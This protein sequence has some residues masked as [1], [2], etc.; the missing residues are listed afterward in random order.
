MGL[1]IEEEDAIAMWVPI[2]IVA[3]FLQTARTAAQQRLRSLLSVS[4]AGFVRYLYGVPLAVIAV[5]AVWRVEGTLPSPPGRF[6]PIVAGAGLAQI[7]GTI[8]MIHAFD[9][10]DY[11]IGT[12]YTKTEIVQVAM[13]SLVILGEPL[14]PL[15]WVASLLCFAGVVVLAGGRNVWRVRDR[16]ALFGLA[17]G[18]LFAITS[19][20]IRAAA[21]SL[22]DASVA[23]RAL[24]TLAV[25]NSMQ[26]VM[27]GGY[28][29]GREREQLGLAVRHW[30]SSAV[31]GVLS[32]CGSAC[33]AT[34]FT[35]ENAARVR[36]FGQV[37]IV[38][39]FGVARV[40]LGEHHGR[41]EYAASAL[42]IAGVVGVLAA[43]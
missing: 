2:T 26:V 37:E 27:H 40:W 34:A 41:R 36:T 7:V 29:A 17:A 18:G 24:L 38:I 20:G 6:W 31:V 12:I 15:G 19:V 21:V 35:L 3:A 9:L 11:A 5:A 42:V 33:W 4:G 43:G 8:C 28:L 25:M 14:R 10:R 30:R 16:A 1:R 39:T 13:F 32:V 23:S 22:G